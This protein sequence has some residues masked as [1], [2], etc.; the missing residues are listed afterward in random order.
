MKRSLINW[1]ILLMAAI[2]VHLELQDTGLLNSSVATDESNFRARVVI[3][4]LI[5]YFSAF[6]MLSNMICQLAELRAF[7]KAS[8]FHGGLDFINNLP[9]WVSSV[10]G[11]PPE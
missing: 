7:M 4:H 6:V 8:I 9:E 5:A 3:W 11:M 10:V 1:F 2:L